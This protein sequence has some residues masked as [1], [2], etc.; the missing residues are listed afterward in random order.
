MRQPFQN[1]VLGHGASIPPGAIEDRVDHVNDHHEYR[2]LNFKSVVQ[3]IVGLVAIVAISYISM[4]GMMKVFESQKAKNDPGISPLASPEWT[5]SP[6]DVQ[7]APHVDL[8]ND[9]ARQDSIL[10][11]LA[12]GPVMSI[13]QAMKEVVSEGLPVRSNVV[14]SEGASGSAGDATDEAERA[15]NDTTAR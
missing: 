6:I 12:K 4:Y 9:R 13:D 7:V 14:M 8:V 5:P 1:K 2:D 11:G 15:A 10:K 3:F